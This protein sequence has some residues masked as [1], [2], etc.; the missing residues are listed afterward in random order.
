MAIGRISG[1]VLKSNLTRNGVDLAFETNLLY[2][3]VTNSRIGIGTSEPTSAL[4]VSGTTTTTDLTVSSDA[5]VRGTTFT[6]SIQSTGSNANIVLDPQGS[7]K[8]ILSGLSFPSSDGTANQVLATDGNGTL[9]FITVSLDSLNTGGILFDDNKITGQRS[10]ENIEIEASGTG[11]IEVNSSI[12]PKTTL[13]V[14]LGSP[15]KKFQDAYFGAGTIYIGDQSITS[16]SSGLVFSNVT[17]SRT[18]DDDT[19]VIFSKTGIGTINKT[20]E[21][22]DSSSMDSALY[23]TVYRD[24]INDQTQIQKISLVHNNSTAH[25]TTSGVVVSGS[26]NSPTFTSDLS[27]GSVQLQT[28]GQSKS[29]SITGYKIGLGDN[30]TASTNGHTAV[31]TPGSIS[32]SYATTIDSWSNSSYRAAKYFISVKNTDNNHVQNIEAVVL[33]DGTT[34]YLN[35]YNIVKTQIDGSSDFITLTASYNGSNV[36]LS[37]QANLGNFGDMAIKMHRILLS[38]D[39]TAEE[40]INL[41]IIDEQTTSSS[42]TIIDTFNVTKLSGALYFVVA[43]N[44][45]AGYYAAGE[46]Y[47][48][49]DGTDSYVA[50]GPN[51]SS[52]DAFSVEYTATLSGNIVNFKAS[53]SVDSATTI[54]AYRIG[55]LE[56]T[57]TGD[58]AETVTLDTAQTI[59]G[60]KTFT[61]GVLTDTIQ[62]PSSNADLT[63][64]ASG[65]G[66]VQILTQKVIM[67]NLPTSDPSV[68]GQL[69]NNS[70]VLNISAG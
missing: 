8:V 56:T 22:F 6:D 32:Q 55:L 19:A 4:Q 57:A 24:D 5:T 53:A 52:N 68:A 54:T 10:N 48:V 45:T 49:S 41:K 63:I 37:A 70:G 28:T 42:S 7:G 16:T 23:F 29:N 26:A 11:V 13:S 1:S 65:T 3:D 30:S 40:Y 2:L 60:A 69:W 21:S 61:A 31:I 51:L 25:H 50:I 33:H 44:D 47:V 36:E 15:T 46:A 9:S 58:V 39:E 18:T 17:T 62:S 64:D 20:I 59:S 66:A 12:V 35:V 27:G 14:S 43:S 67:A 38:S 34:A